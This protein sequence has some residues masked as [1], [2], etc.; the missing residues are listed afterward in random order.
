MKQGMAGYLIAALLVVMTVALAGQDGL[1][2]PITYTNDG[3]IALP[4]YGK[5]VFIGSGLFSSVQG[6]NSRF[7]TVFIE[8]AAYDQTSKR[9]RGPIAR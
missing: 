8:P 4:D 6:P 9:A 5:W 3:G 7:S 2:K 1:T